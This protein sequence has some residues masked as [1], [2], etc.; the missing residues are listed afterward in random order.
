MDWVTLGKSYVTVA[1]FIKVLRVTVRFQ[2]SIVGKLPAGNPLDFQAPTLPTRSIPNRIHPL[3]TAL[4]TVTENVV[5]IGGFNLSP[6]CLHQRC[7][8]FGLRI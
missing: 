7:V 1:T 6:P 2:P 3:K 5:A 4:V 8:A